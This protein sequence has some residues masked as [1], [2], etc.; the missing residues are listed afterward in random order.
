M[1]GP[2]LGV[3]H[4]PA[5]VPRCTAPGKQRCCPREDAA[6][7]PA[8]LLLQMRRKRQQAKRGSVPP[9]RALRAGAAPRQAAGQGQGIRQRVQWR[10]WLLSACQNLHPRHVGTDPLH[11]QALTAARQLLPGWAA[12]GSCSGLPAPHSTSRALP[13]PTGAKDEMLSSMA[14]SQ[15]QTCLRAQT[16]A[17]GMATGMDVHTGTAIRAQT[18]GRL[19]KCQAKG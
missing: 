11:R 5:D 4:P 16:D 12:P 9:E 3:T 19:Q 15:A 8:A 18:H 2:Q 14:W 10:T 6:P 1:L 13:A 17:H 7:S